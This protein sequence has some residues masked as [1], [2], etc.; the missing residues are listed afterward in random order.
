M[1][2]GHLLHGAIAGLALAPLAWHLDPALGPVLGS[3]AWIAGTTVGSLVPD[4]DHPKSRLTKALGPIT[5]V[6]NKVLVRLSKAVF[7]AT[8]TNRDYKDT[9]GHRCLTHT[10][11]FAAVLAVGVSMGLEATSAHGA[12]VLLGASLGAGC[13]AHLFGDS[14]TNS[15]VPWLWPL[16]DRRTGRRW[17]HY[18]IPRSLRFET[19]GGTSHGKALTWAAH[20]EHIV[21]GLSMAV[22]VVLPFTYVWLGWGV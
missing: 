13:L 17:Q 10:P 12:A 15:G 5:W 22:V 3:T 2:R 4:L 9:N 14:L 19:G 11:V 7:Y 1:S 8:R 21:T 16:K 18:G 6:L 20:G